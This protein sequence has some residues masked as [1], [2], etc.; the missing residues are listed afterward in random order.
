VISGWSGRLSIRTLLER[1]LA[2]AEHAL[3]IRPIQ[4][5][6]GKELCGHAAASA[7]IEVLAAMAYAAGLGAKRFVGKLGA[8]FWVWV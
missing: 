2:V 6:P 3:R 7:R 5:Q 4:W 1:G 8:G